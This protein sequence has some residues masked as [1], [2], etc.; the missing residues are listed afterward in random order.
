VPKRTGPELV[1]PAVGQLVVSFER[2]LTLRASPRIA[3][4]S[5]EVRDAPRGVETTP[6][7]EQEVERL[8]RT[9]GARLWRAVMAY[10]GNR[11][12][13]SDA[14]AE[15]FTQLL[16]RGEAVHTPLPWL[17]RSAFRIAA[18]ELKTRGQVAPPADDPIY[19]APEPLTD[20]LRALR[21]LSPNQREAVILH[22]Y[23][24]LPSAEIAR[25]MGIGQATV[26]VHASQAR[27]RLRRLLEDRN[28]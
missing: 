27:R 11:E 6:D 15:A 12:I 3:S 14:V 21:R 5:D 17:W 23:V 24:D 4:Y 2:G 28:A 9:E 16:A 1:R 8:Y 22:D 19:E 25:I 13:A 26:R 18:G 7:R 20:M 10:S